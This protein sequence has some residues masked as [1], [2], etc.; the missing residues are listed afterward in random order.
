MRS[1]SAE[2]QSFQSTLYHCNSRHA[3][4]SGTSALPIYAS[5]LCI[6]SARCACRCSAAISGRA[7]GSAPARQRAAERRP[8]GLP[9]RGTESRRQAPARFWAVSAFSASSPFSGPALGGGPAGCSSATTGFGIDGRPATR[10]R[11]GRAA[12]EWSPAGTC[13]RCRSRRIRCPGP[14]PRPS[15]ASCSQDRAEVRASAP[16]GVESSWTCTVGGPGL[17]ASR[18]NEEQPARLNPAAAIAMVRRMIDPSLCSVF[19]RCG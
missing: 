14:S 4:H 6:Q 9:G 15:R 1:D 5:S 16:C 12:P 7:A 2:V 19:E 10:D 18:E 11:R 8:P 13:S 17:K 3:R